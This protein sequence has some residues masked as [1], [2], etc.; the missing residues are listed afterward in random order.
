ML[1]DF[2]GDRKYLGKLILEKKDSLETVFKGLKIEI[3]LVKIFLQ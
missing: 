1:D 2:S 3:Y